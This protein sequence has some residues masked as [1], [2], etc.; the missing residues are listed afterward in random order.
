MNWGLRDDSAVKSAAAEAA[1]EEDKVWLESAQLLL[2]PARGASPT[3][4]FYGNLTRVRAYTHACII[5][6]R[7][8]APKKQIKRG[9]GGTCPK[10]Q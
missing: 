9:C 4:G 10:S 8:K 3:P 2:T 5:K 1:D 7:K 6:L